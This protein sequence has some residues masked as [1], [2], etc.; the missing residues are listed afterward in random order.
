MNTNTRALSDGASLDRLSHALQAR[1]TMGISPASL[2][3]AYLDWLVHYIDPETWQT[4]TPSQEGSWWPAW[5]S[6]LAQHSS[7]CVAAP[8]LGAPEQGYSALCDAPG[9]YVL[10]T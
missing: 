1:F 5:L 10:Q 7:G 6:W 9:T 2:M 4:A 8:A 3:L